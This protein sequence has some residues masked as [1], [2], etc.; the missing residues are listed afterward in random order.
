MRLELARDPPAV[1]DVEAQQVCGFTVE[2]FAQVLADLL[3]RGWAWSREP[4]SVQMR[5]ITGLAAEFARVQNRDCDLLA[6]SYPGTALE[7]LTDWERICGLPDPCTG[8][9]GTIQQRRAAILA[10]LAMR[11]GQ[12]KQYYIDIAYAVGFQITITEYKPF[13]VGVSHSGDMLNGEDWLYYWRVTSFEESTKIYSF[14]VGQ[15]VTHEA[16]RYWSNTLL[17]C[18][19]LSVAPAHTIVHFAYQQSWS[20]WDDPGNPSRWD[21]GNSIW[22][23][24]L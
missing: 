5:M 16:L 23:Q 1:S 11:G 14:R 18:V 15:S 13:R 4:G 7:T 19:I 10:K 17:E 6:E 8:V 22:D 2:D 20:L 12:N 21:D 9:L 24:E 3:P